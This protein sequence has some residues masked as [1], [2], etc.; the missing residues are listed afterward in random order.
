M[1]RNLYLIQ[2]FPHIAYPVPSL[3]PDRRE[4]I[5]MPYS[6][7]PLVLVAS[8]FIGFVLS[9]SVFASG[10]SQKPAERSV[11]AYT[12]DSFPGDIVDAMSAILAQ[13][14]ISLKVEQSGDSGSVYTR[15]YL[16]RQEPRADV[17][18]GLDQTY[19]HAI[20]A[21]GLAEAYRPASFQPAIPELSLNPDL[22]VLAFDYGYITLNYDS[23][24]LPN[25][26]RTWA[27]L[28][29][30]RLSQSII[31][32]NPGT[33]SPGRNF[34]LLSI[35][36]LGEEGFLDYWRQLKPNILTVAGGWS[37]GYGLYA[38]G[39]APLV[40]S[41]DSSPAY[42]RIFEGSE[43]YKT[44]AIEGSGYLQV[45][46]A[47]IVRGTRD[48][49]AAEKLIDALLS[50]EVQ[51]LIP[52][53]QFMYPARAGVALPEGYLAPEQA[54]TSPVLMDEARIA[55]NYTRWLAEWEEVLR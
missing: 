1:S 29:D 28:L 48:R 41:Y 10:S 36:Q 38:Q 22:P 53:N 13:D 2:Y 34:L 51:A 31:M 23:E 25:P 24:A 18:I 7:R 4:G 45:E 20:L 40:V 33:S 49:E 39:E 54:V 16:E 55:E 6:R 43:R 27:E 9:V 12:Y 42:H 52:L 15:L 3:P 14:G 21:D 30:P 50:P 5:H 47:G 11:L 35:E 37:E 44:L 32:L 46:V 26:P 19:I 8:V 17:F